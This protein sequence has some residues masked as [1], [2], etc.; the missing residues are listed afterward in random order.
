MRSSVYV[1]TMSSVAFIFA[2]GCGSN[3][4]M[5]FEPQ[6][7]TDAGVEVAQLAPLGSSNTT[8]AAATTQDRQNIMACAQTVVS[9]PDAKLDGV[10]LFQPAQK[11]GDPRA[12]EPW[13][14]YLAAG[15]EGVILPGP[16]VTA[17]DGLLVTGASSLSLVGARQYSA[18]G[19]HVVVNP[20]LAYDVAIDDFEYEVTLARVELCPKDGS[21]E[22]WFIFV[23]NP[24][25]SGVAH[26]ITVGA[27]T[28]SKVTALQPAV[29]VEVR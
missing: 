27:T 23:G 6:V 9:N 14:V 17:A 25:A 12:G 5:P 24:G 21:I 15:T 4:A 10:A 18:D 7:A 1:P 11:Q 16:T 28:T 20:S 3:E 8:P 2:L 13:Y 26:T 29:T 22:S 19:Y